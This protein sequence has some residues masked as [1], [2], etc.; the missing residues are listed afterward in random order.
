MVVTWARVLLQPYSFELD[1][2]GNIQDMILLVTSPV[3][4][5]GREDGY[6]LMQENIKHRRMNHAQRNQ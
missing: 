2:D 3:R 6:I 5:F 4:H 1:W